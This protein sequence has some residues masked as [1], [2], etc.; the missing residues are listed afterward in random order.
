MAPSRDKDRQM[1]IQLRSQ[2]LSIKEICERVKASKGSVSPWVAHI[3]LTSA[4][5]MAM[6]IRVAPQTHAGREAASKKNREKCREVR[7]A[8][9]LRGYKEAKGAPL[10]V[11]GCM[12]YW[13]E[14]T[15]SV[16]AAAMTNTD[17]GLLAKFVEFLLFMGVEIEKVKVSC[18]V[19]DTPGNA[20]KL[21]C[22]KF[23]AKSLG[24]KSTSVKVFSAKDNRGV[25][26]RKCRYPHGIGRV[27]VYDVSLVQRIYGGIERYAGTEMVFGRK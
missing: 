6:K 16:T 23:W 27:E 5:V 7:D 2:G 24:V 8:A 25:Y 19:H 20:S 21:A 3:K 18:R 26:T 12:L 10:H 11:A 22:Q 14:G 1:A 13:A 15:K 9:R 17:P 4:Q